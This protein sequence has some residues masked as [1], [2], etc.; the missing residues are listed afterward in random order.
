MVTRKIEWSKTAF[1]QF[2]SALTFIASDSVLH[3]EKVRKDILSKLNLALKN[4]ECFPKDKFRK[5]NDG[6]FRAFEIHHY[7]LAYRFTGNTIKVLRLRHTGRE[8]KEY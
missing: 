5:N 8:P 7:R 3:A 1:K 6:S 4:P 2:G